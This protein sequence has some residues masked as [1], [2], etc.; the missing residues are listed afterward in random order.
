MATLKIDWW[1]TVLG[2]LGVVIGIALIAVG[3]LSGRFHWD[4]VL[5]GLIMLIAGLTVMRWGR[6]AR[7]ISIRP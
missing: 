1:R 4:L 2:E 5:R 6:G 3:T 7:A